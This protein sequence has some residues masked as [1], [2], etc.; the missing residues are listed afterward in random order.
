[1]C[2]GIDQSESPTP[3]RQSRGGG[4]AWLPCAPLATQVSRTFLVIETMVPDI[5]ASS[6]Q[7]LNA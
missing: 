5:Q 3:L 4:A 7:S 2:C 1:M 6:E